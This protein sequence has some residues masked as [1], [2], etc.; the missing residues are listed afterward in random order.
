MLVAC[1]RLSGLKSLLQSWRSPMRCAVL[2][3]PINALMKNNI[4]CTGESCV[5]VA[6]RD[7]FVPG[8]RTRP[9]NSKKVDGEFSR[10]VAPRAVSAI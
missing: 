2:V 4:Q 8:M 6:G 7:V 9:A 5:F 10:K 3:P 1:G